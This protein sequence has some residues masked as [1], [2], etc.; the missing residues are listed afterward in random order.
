[1]ESFKVLPGVWIKANRFLTDD[2]ELITVYPYNYIYEE[3]SDKLPI[4][5][6][7]LLELGEYNMILQVVE[8]KKT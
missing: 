5:C 6:W 8:K 7:I 1:M 2:N 3:W 4:K